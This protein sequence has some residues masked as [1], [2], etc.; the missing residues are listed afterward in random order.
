MTKCPK[1]GAKYTIQPDICAQCGTHFTPENSIPDP[2]TAAL[3]QEQQSRKQQE[4]QREVYLTLRRE[5]AVQ[6]P[7]L[8]AKAPTE[9]AE[10]DSAEKQQEQT[11]PAQ[12]TEADD[13][14]KKNSKAAILL[15]AV[16]IIALGGVAF[17]SL[18]DGFRSDALQTESFA[19]YRR[20]NTLYFYRDDTGKTIRL[21]PN[22][23]PK[24]ELSDA[25]LQKLTQISPDGSRIYYPKNFTEDTCTI[26]YRDLDSPKTSQ[27]LADILMY[28]EVT[29]AVK[30]IGRLNET[31]AFQFTDMLPPYILDGN[32]IYYINNDDALCRKQP[33]GEEEVLSD[34]VVR[35]WKVTGMEGIFFLTA[36][37]KDAYDFHGMRLPAAV[38]TN[39]TPWSV[40]ETMEPFCNL[41]YCAG[42][43]E[44]PELISKDPISVWAVPYLDSDRYLYSWSIV[45]ESAIILKQT[46]LIE[47]EQRLIN[48][49]VTNS[50]DLLKTLELLCAY[51]DGSFYY[52]WHSNAWLSSSRL[53][54]VCYYDAEQQ[55]CISLQTLNH[56]DLF[57]QLDICRTAPYL[58]F[59]NNEASKPYL[60]YSGQAVIM[61]FDDA[62][63]VTGDLKLQFDTQFPILY[64][65]ETEN[66][67]SQG[68]QRA[69]EDMGSK[70]DTD[71]TYPNIYYAIPNEK[72]MISFQ[73]L[74]DAPENGT[75]FANQ[76]KN[77]SAPDIFCLA[78]S[79]FRLDQKSGTM[80]LLQTTTGPIT[81]ISR[82]NGVLFCYSA[83]DSSVSIFRDADMQK[84][85]N[86]LLNE[87]AWRPIS[88]LSEDTLFTISADRTLRLCSPGAQKKIGTADALFGTGLL[89]QAYLK[90]TSSS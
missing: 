39:Q 57:E 46:D 86:E 15:A 73:K 6:Q 43:G 63:T 52:V 80:Q 30:E 38:E 29:A 74:E 64:A 9:E 4:E 26:A 20:D 37:H 51:P 16:G 31:E 19:F 28:P 89:P 55:N 14:Q 84:L 65:A 11:S 79:L 56:E 7:Q 71:M 54:T 83:Q 42:D 90:Y 45:S 40:W 36:L 82:S 44:T 49:A 27:D 17:F 32:T 85:S 69:L 48:Y 76:P 21:T 87:T 81:R 1:C 18:R 72:Q 58:T 78:S 88:P 75:W 33:D 62:V 41:Y 22:G 13:K 50:E 47:G 53:S 8:E 10:E 5:K 66:E 23:I 61:S 12:R 25:Y 68:L 77:A 59:C 70:T 60:Y 3:L 67:L 35:Y 2:F 24:S 34:S